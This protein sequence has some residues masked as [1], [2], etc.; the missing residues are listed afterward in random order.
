MGNQ[1]I[2]FAEKE[3]IVSRLLSTVLTL[4]KTDGQFLDNLATSGIHGGFWFDALDE[5]L[6]K[7]E[8]LA[9]GAEFD[10]HNVL[11]FIQALYDQ[12]A[13]ENAARE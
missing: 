1:R 6:D 11:A 4:Q 5:I 7:I 3:Y 2:T 12:I 8:L 10:L 13:E 9:T